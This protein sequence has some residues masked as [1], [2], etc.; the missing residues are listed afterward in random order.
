MTRATECNSVMPVRIYDG[1]TLLQIQELRRRAWSANGELP[2]FIARQDILKDEH[3]I[4]GR[5]WAILL[6][7]RP[8]AAARMCIHSEVDTSP[9]SEALADYEDMI[10]AP[11]ASL[12]RLVVHPDFRG[13]GL[14][15]VLDKVRI[16]EAELNHCNSIVSVTETVPRIDKLRRLGFAHLGTTGIR[17][18]SYAESHVMLKT[19]ATKKCGGSLV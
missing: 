8:I 10:F 14:A 16:A 4:H 2:D 11:L 12:T 1:P 9:D 19:L 17:Y 7:G 15:S 13:R 18:L 3:D 6:E 5:H